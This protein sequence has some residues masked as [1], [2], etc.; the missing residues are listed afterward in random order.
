MQTSKLIKRFIKINFPAL[1]HRDFLYF[2]TGQAVSLIGTW[3]QSVAQ[4]WLVY[5]MTD[6]PFLTGLIGA[7]QFL[8]VMLLSLFAGVVID[9][10]PKKKILYIT[11][12]ISMVLAL[13][14]SIL[15]LT[16][17]IQYWHVLAV[18]FLLG[19][20]NTIDMPT[21]QAY[22]IEITGREDLMNAIALNSMVFN[23]A[24]IIGPS[25]GGLI[26]ASAGAGWC[27]LINGLSFVAVLY[28][29]SRIKSQPFV[30]KVSS[31][32]RMLSEIREGLS[33]I[34]GDIVLV[35]TLLMV[36]VAGIFIFNFNVL[37]PVFT[38]E[39]LLLD[40]KTFGFL[41]SSLGFGSMIGALL[42]SVKGRK[43]PKPHIIF[44]S[45]III[46]TLF[47]IVGFSRAYLVT[48]LVLAVI[49]IFNILFST[50]ANST[51]QIISKDEYR[52]R[53]MSVYTL[54]FAGTTPIG[55]VYAGFVSGRFGADIAFSI[56][57]LFILILA[58][59]VNFILKS[60]TYPLTNEKAREI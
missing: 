45:L 12:T 60:R 38:R 3:M 24:R 54:L 16:G 31:N 23:L 7:V 18:A 50:T 53:V 58:V 41:M 36:T 9:K 35:K 52:S 56:S 5:T 28:G 49:G 37:I 22:I 29:L 40:E 13:I 51:I 59:A 21:R 55:N 2:W 42:V 57:G 39:V 32:T 34:K 8:P 43:G 27:F 1:T 33:Y 14:L 25:I 10:L 15:V 48:A 47:I 17:N 11:Q 20:S 30:R 46:S 6:S 44:A 19:C 4:A 26:L